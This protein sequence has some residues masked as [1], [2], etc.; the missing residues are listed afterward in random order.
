MLMSLAHEE[1]NSPRCYLFSNGVT[2]FQRR[3]LYQT[4]GPFVHVG[5][6]TLHIWQRNKSDKWMIKDLVSAIPYPPLVRVPLS[7]VSSHLKC[8]QAVFFL[9]SLAV[10]TRSTQRHVSVA[11]VKYSGLRPSEVT[12]LS[13]F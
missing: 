2:A 6:E 7:L 4:L 10:C 12:W 8:Q 3:W 9:Q 13:A 1:I 5:F 11:A